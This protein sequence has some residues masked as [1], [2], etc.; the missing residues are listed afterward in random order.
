M[1]IYDEE[2]PSVFQKY[3]VI[4]VCG[5]IAAIAIVVVVW[6]ENS[7]VETSRSHARTK[8]SVYDRFVA[9]VPPR[10]PPSAVPL[11][12]LPPP[13]E[14]EQKMIAQEPVNAAE[15]KPGAKRRAGQ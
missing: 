5:L 1:G 12:H 2:E 6:P 9:A 15:S 10:A 7:S 8:R 14:S 4:I 13:M 11:I 3:R